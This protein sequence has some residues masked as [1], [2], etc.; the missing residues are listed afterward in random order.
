MSSRTLYFIALA[1]LAISLTINVINGF[2]T[3]NTIL[4]VAAVVVLGYA[5]YKKVW[6]K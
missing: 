2:T 4:T 1:L 6:K 5:T 3:A